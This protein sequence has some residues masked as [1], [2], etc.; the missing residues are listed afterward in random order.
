MKTFDGR[1]LVR[2]PADTKE[3]AYSDFRALCDPDDEHI[4]YS[5]PFDALIVSMEVSADCEWEIVRREVI[6]R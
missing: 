2:K 5:T 4:I 3:G 1:I 6:A